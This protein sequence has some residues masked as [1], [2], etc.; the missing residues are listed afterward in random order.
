[1][2]W[3]E[4]RIQSLLSNV[5]SRINE[6]YSWTI[7]FEKD[8]N[9]HNPHRQQLL[10][11]ITCQVIR[12]RIIRSIY[13]WNAREPKFR[14][15]VDSYSRPSKKPNDTGRV[16]TKKKKVW[17]YFL[18]I[19]CKAPKWYGYHPSVYYSC[20]RWWG[21]ILGKTLPRKMYFWNMEK[22]KQQIFSRSCSL[23]LFQVSQAR[24]DW[25]CIY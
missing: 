10:S 3:D 17:R 25:R 19:S 23:P 18:Y 22:W 7:K 9:P 1:M 6:K 20:F 21:R 5:L 14:V 13:P 15:I 11:L 4:V 12:S 2:H 8:F 24:M 16:W